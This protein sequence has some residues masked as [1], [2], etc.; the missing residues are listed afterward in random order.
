MSS[1]ARMYHEKWGCNVLLP[2]ARGHGESGG[3]DI[4]FGWPERSIRIFKKV[5]Y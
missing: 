4:G 5:Q 3:D 1:Y 2:D